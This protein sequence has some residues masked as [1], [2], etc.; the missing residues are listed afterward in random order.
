MGYAR[1]LDGHD[2]V[3]IAVWLRRLTTFGSDEAKDARKRR[4]G[5]FL[6]G[7]IEHFYETT[8]DTNSPNLFTTEVPQSLLNVPHKRLTVKARCLME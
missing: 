8:S 4:K 3:F 7:V 5:V 1:E 6:C 2:T